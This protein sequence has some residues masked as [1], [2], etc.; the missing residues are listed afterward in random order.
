[1]NLI[2]V[3]TS[4]GAISF[5]L[6]AATLLATHGLQGLTW[7][8]LALCAVSVVYMGL[9]RFP[10]PGISERFNFTA[11]KQAVGTPLVVLLT[12]IMFFYIAIE[13]STGM[14]ANRFFQVA[15]GKPESTSLLFVTGFWLA[16]LI[17]RVIAAQLLK[18]MPDTLLL[19]G[20][21]AGACIGLAILAL[22]PVPALAVAGLW[23]TGLCYG[24][25]FPT[26]LGTAGTIFKDTF[27]TVL[28][29]TIGIGII[30]S[31][32]L[33]KIIGSTW[34]DAT[35]S[36][37]IWFLFLFALLLLVTQLL[38]HRQVR[39]LQAVDNQAQSHVI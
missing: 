21:I 6:I 28:G 35:P 33:P 13:V 8:T 18:T 11:A 37:A 27:G 39:R 14:W 15:H 24:P 26:T 9:S 1:L 17:G 38:V 16:F 31:M 12:A 5:P 23:L 20:A 30:G 22:A 32:I 10:P 36:V 25:V 34:N 4:L 3:F 29:V 2:N 19:V 7:V